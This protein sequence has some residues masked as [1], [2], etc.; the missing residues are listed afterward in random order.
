MFCIV[1]YEI[2]KVNYKNK[3]FGI[4]NKLWNKTI[5]FLF[6]IETPGVRYRIFLTF[7]SITRSIQKIISIAGRKKELR[8]KKTPSYGRQ[9]LIVKPSVIGKST[10]FFIS[11][12]TYFVDSL[13]LL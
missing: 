3:N 11:F 1:A 10:S 13:N 5:C 7:I 6:N 2:I 8:I 9:F 12:F 4:N